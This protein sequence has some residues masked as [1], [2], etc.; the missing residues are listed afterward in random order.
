[1]V[2]LL[3]QQAHTVYKL[4]S[5]QDWLN[6]RARFRTKSDEDSF[7]STLYHN[8]KYL[9]FYI[10]APKKGF[11]LN[12]I[13]F[14]P[15]L[16]FACQNWPNLYRP[17]ILSFPARHNIWADTEAATVVLKLAFPSKRNRLDSQRARL[18]FCRKMLLWIFRRIFLPPRLRLKILYQ[19]RKKSRKSPR[20]AIWNSILSFEQNSFFPS[21]TNLSP[22]ISLLQKKLQKW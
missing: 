21:A 19:S 9:R 4:S 18:I 22:M 11:F 2:L 10:Q 15:L 8:L 1:M 17:N 20:S 7:P 16:I 13:I 3:L 14:K 6:I 5:R 12:S